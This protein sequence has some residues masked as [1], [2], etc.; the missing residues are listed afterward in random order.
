MANPSPTT[1][2]SRLR[3][4][5]WQCRRKIYER[6]DEAEANGEK[7]IVSQ[8][9]AA[10][11]QLTDTDK[12]AWDMQKKLIKAPGGSKAI[13]TGLEHAVADAKAVKSNLKKAEDIIAEAEKIIDIL[14]NLRI[15]FG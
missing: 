11:K 13:I 3:D 5:L 7:S 2:L 6:Q 10:T 8:C 9:E 12:I 14:K 4:Q 15:I 1:M